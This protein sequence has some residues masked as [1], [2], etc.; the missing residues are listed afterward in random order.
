MLAMFLL[1]SQWEGEEALKMF[2]RGMVLLIVL[3]TTG[4]EPSLR[5]ELI[6]LKAERQIHLS[7]A[8]IVMP[9]ATRRTSV[10]YHHKT[11]RVLLSMRSVWQRHERSMEVHT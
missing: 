11:V 1:P 2:M 8:T 5:P 7:I 9:K 3:T 10:L 6:H 4:E